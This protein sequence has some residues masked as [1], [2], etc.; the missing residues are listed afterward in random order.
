MRGREASRCAGPSDCLPDAEAAARRVRAIVTRPAGQA[1]TWVDAL[2]RH[3]VDAVA[4][5]LIEIAPAADPAP[6]R[7]AWSGLAGRRLVVFVSPNAALQF[8]AERPP[9]AG[10]PDGVRAASVGPGTTQALRRLGVPATAIAEP[11]AASA[12]FDSEALWQVLRDADGHG[13]SVLVVRGD[14]GRDWLADTLRAHGAAL[15]F[16]AAYRRRAPTPDA[17]GR[18]LLAEAQA[19]PAAHAWIF[20]SSQ[21]IDH[22][23]ELAPSVAGSAATAIV[24]HPRIG[25]RARAA[26][27]GR[28]L[29]ARPT[30][31]GVSAC[32]QSA[33][34]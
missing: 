28:L 25:E 33:A 26:G 21:A 29:D 9:A 15:D 19:R 5:P 34:P 8:F 7:A 20:S 12:Q 18:A 30:P 23:L 27:F 14:G 6:V 11:D 2:R 17:A 3:G 22:L 1:T 4:L 13:A 16:V 10:W 31:D 24:T 32:L